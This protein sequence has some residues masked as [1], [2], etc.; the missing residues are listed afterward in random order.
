MIQIQQIF[1]ALMNLSTSNSYVKI[2]SDQVVRQIQQNIVDHFIY[3]IKRSKIVSVT[4]L[5]YSIA[6]ASV[7]LLI[8]K[9]RNLIFSICKIKNCI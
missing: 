3:G 2:F 8:L 4:S 7:S 9:F 6:D 1:D 5:I